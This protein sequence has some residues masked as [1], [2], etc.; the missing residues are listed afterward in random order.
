MHIHAHRQTPCDKHSCAS[1]EGQAGGCSPQ[2]A[3][4]AL[5]LVVI[6]QVQRVEGHKAEQAALRHAM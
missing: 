4:L 1:P 5:A 3:D 2:C 6:A